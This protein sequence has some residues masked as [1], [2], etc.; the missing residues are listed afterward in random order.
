[1]AI[2]ELLKP[3]YLL[4]YALTLVTPLYCAIHESGCPPRIEGNK[5][6]PAIVIEPNIPYG[7]HLLQNGAQIQE[8]SWDNFP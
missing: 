6:H 1:M 2:S 8:L 3:I 4:A 5:T 7:H